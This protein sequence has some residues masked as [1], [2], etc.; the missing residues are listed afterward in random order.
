MGEGVGVGVGVG[1]G[2]VGVGV[3]LAVGLGVG[4]H[5]AQTSHTAAFRRKSAMSIDLIHKAST[6]PMGCA[7]R[8]ASENARAPNW[9]R[10]PE[11]CLH[12]LKTLLALSSWQLMQV[13][14]LGV[15]AGDGVSVGDGVCVGD[16]VQVGLQSTL[17]SCSP[18]IMDSGLYCYEAC[19]G[20]SRRPC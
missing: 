6:R 19:A 20:R 18:A 16:G 12:A 10:L 8:D 13:R 5:D 9:C 3:G 11:I 1:G 4:L 14:Y 17:K 7:R 2:G 15:Y